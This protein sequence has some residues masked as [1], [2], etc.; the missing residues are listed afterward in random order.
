MSNLAT[1]LVT[2]SG[3]SGNANT[4][5]SN[6]NDALSSPDGFANKEKFHDKKFNVIVY[7]IDECPR[8][9]PKQSRFKSDLNRVVSVLSEIDNS[10]QSQSISDIYRLGKYTLERKH[11]R[12]I[13][14]KFIR[15]TDVSRVLSKRGLL[16]HPVFIK[17]DL[18][19]DL[20]RRES[21]LL[22]ERWNL[23]K[24]GIPR[25]DIKIHDS[26]LYVKRKLFGY[27][28][29]KSEFQY[30]SNSALLAQVDIQSLAGNGATSDHVTSVPSCSAAESYPAN[31]ACP[32]T[33]KTSQHDVTHS[34]AQAHTP[35][36][37]VELSSGNGVTSEH[38]STVPT[39]PVA[40]SS[41]A[42]VCPT[43]SNVNLSSQTHSSPQSQSLSDPSLPTPAKS[44]SSS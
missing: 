22:R 31:E 41:P 36:V 21:V 24:S 3:E 43:T 2:G 17:P 33:S 39:S 12:P 5:M 40:V 18:T 8:G 7:G 19:P 16:H 44:A 26:R 34:C 25:A 4:C 42:E 20:R 11:P 1:L 10:V 6:G 15:V 14:V 9:T 29:N 38:V 13:L 28:N 37:N 23:I 35:Q 27:F 32:T 30:S